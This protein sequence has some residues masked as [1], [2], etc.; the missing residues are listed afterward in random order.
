MDQQTREKLLNARAVEIIAGYDGFVDSIIRVVKKRQSFNTYTAY[1]KI[2]EFAAAIASVAGKSGNFELVT[3]RTKLGGNATLMAGALQ[4]F[5]HHIHYIGSLGKPEIEVE[6]KAF[7]DKCKSV[8]SLTPAAK[9]DALEFEDGKLLMGKM[10]MLKEITRDNIEKLIG[11]QQ[12]K[13][14]TAGSDLLIFNN[15]T[16]L[17][18]MNGIIKL[19]RELLRETGSSPDVFVDLAD[20]FKRDDEALEE[21]LELLKSFS[22]ETG[23]I[24]S[25]NERESTLVGKILDVEEEDVKQR[26]AAI[27]KKSGIT[28]IVI[29]P[30]KG[31]ATVSNK[32]PDPV[33]VD[34]PYTDKPKI[35]TGAGDHFNAGF[36]HGWLAGLSAEDC[37]RC[38]VF[39]SGYYVR[40]GESPTVGQL[41]EF[42]ES[43]E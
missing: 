17:P 28:A 16:M 3:E 19:F 42:M 5:N 30:L 39:T 12:L 20:P 9:T 2:S 27:R 31:A 10:E 21:V 32:Y 37:L 1:A 34:G 14:M 40:N 25:M 11:R 23:V 24:L 36:A 13:Q 15:W 29:H 8:Y 6:F 22:E 4:A 18:Y 7:A 38:G 41:L 43:W 26:A 33:W 35:T